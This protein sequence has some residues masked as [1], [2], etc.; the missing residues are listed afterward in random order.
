VAAQ[1]AIAQEIA[2]LKN[3]PG[4]PALDFSGL[5]AAVAG[6]QGLVPAPVAPPV[7]EPTAPADGSTTSVA[8]A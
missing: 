6:F 7:T 2:D 8:T 1:A 3:Q 4:A 5:D